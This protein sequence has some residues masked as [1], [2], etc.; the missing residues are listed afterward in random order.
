MKPRVGWATLPAEHEDRKRRLM[1][2][3]K[4]IDL[5]GDSSITFEELVQFLSQKGN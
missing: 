4:E 1:K 5:D 3:F 2:D